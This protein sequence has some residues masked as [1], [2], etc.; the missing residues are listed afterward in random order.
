[1]IVNIC[2][3]G[4]KAARTLIGV[5]LLSLLYIFPGD[6]AFVGLVGLVPIFTVLTGYCPIKHLAGITSCCSRHNK[7]WPHHV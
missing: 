5:A 1:M 3:R 2:Y 4:E 7:H 6:W